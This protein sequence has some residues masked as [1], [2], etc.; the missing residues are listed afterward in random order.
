MDEVACLLNSLEPLRQQ[1]IQLGKKKDALRSELRSELYELQSKLQ[2]NAQRERMLATYRELGELRIDLDFIKNEAN[3]K[4]PAQGEKEIKHLKEIMD[5]DKD[6][7]ISIRV[8]TNLKDPK[9]RASKELTVQQLCVSRNQAVEDLFLQHGIKKSRFWKLD[10]MYG[11]KHQS[12]LIEKV[13]R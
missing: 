9:A 1:Q 5:I 7:Q 4:N 3:L 12:V 13:K 11:A 6:D 10:P 2:A 8:T